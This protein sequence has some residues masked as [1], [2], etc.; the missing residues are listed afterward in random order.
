MCGL[1]LSGAGCTCGGAALGRAGV[2][3]GW[4]APQEDPWWSRE[5]QPNLPDIAARALVEGLDTRRCASSP[6]LTQM[7]QPAR[8]SC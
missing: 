3:L 5:L 7:T 2:L 1:L 6:A 4:W 8:A